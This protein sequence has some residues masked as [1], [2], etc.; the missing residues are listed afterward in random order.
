MARVALPLHSLGAAV[1]GKCE[2]RSPCSGDATAIPA[3]GAPVDLLGAGR[4][5]LPPKFVS[6]APPPLGRDEV[7]VIHTWMASPSFAFAAA[8]VLLPSTPSVA[9][10]MVPTTFLA[11]VPPQTYIHMLS[12]STPKVHNI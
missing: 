2:R 4:S 1:S 12:Y 5:P 9:P 6:S 7:D 10:V 8:A 11:P 3:G